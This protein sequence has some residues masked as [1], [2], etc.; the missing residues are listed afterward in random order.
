MAAI[1][2][3][4]LM[5]V[6]TEETDKNALTDMIPAL[7]RLHVFVQEGD[8]IMESHEIDENFRNKPTKKTLGH[9]EKVPALWCSAR[10]S[11]HFVQWIPDSSCCL[12]TGSSWIQVF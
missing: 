2:G 6:A 8:S 12:M 9:I 7:G 3:Q 4:K 1:R 5:A 10:S 11:T